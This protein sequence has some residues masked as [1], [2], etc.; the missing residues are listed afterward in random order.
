MPK[1]KQISANGDDRVA[2]AA[3]MVLYPLCGGITGA[4]L[5]LAVGILP[6]FGLHTEAWFEAFFF[7]SIGIGAVAGTLLGFL[8]ASQ[9]RSSREVQSLIARYR[10]GAVP[11]ARQAALAADAASYTISTH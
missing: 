3:S 10:R 6:Y 9:Q 1:L 4:L 2:T 5:G 11:D 7:A 8:T